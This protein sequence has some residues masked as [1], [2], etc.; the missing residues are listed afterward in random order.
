MS[1]FLHPPFRIVNTYYINSSPPK[2]ISYNLSA[3][4]HGLTLSATPPEFMRKNF[5]YRMHWQVVAVLDVSNFQ[6]GCHQNTHFWHI[7]PFFHAITSCDTVTLPGM[8]QEDSLVRL[9]KHPWPDRHTGSPNKSSLRTQ[10]AIAIHADTRA[11]CCTH[12][13]QRLWPSEGHRS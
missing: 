9:A 6:D 2:Q 5:L 11:L 8:W 10:P 3:R 7:S 4:G 13:Q 12:V 1:H